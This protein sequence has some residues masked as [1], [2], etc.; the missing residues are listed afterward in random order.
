MIYFDNA[1]TTKIDK[2]AL[3][4]MNEAYEISWA[5]PS[6]LHRL[7]FDSEK[8]IKSARKT[9]ASKLKVSENSIYFSP[10]ATIANN[11]VLKKYDIKGKNI[12]VSVI[13]HSSISNLVVNLE[14]EV[15]FVKV[16]KWGFVNQKDIVD[17]IDENTILV[18]IIHV[19]NEIGSIND[20]NNLAKIVKEKNPKIKFHSDGVQAFKK[21]EVSLDN[22]DYYTISSHKIHGPKGVGALFVRNSN[23]ISPI[24]IGGGQEKGIF[25]G[26]ENIPAIIGF[27]K[28]CELDNNYD[29]VSEINGYLRSEISKID[30]SIILSP[31]ENSSPFILNI[32]IERIG[33]EILLH[34][35]EM[36]DIYIST[37]SACNKKEKSKV[38]EAL[39]LP[40]GF[41][42][43][44][45]RISLSKDNTI[46]EAQIFIEKLHEKIETIRR[47]IGWDGY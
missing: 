43:G 20:I 25:S 4:T 45:I 38:L 14:V 23:E 42:D 13:E 37:G 21:I 24:Y 15:R 39:N 7:G 34:Y 11:T 44:C 28:A 32:C 46:E 41:T 12:I 2:S 26:T 31:V 8:R 6:S 27:E 1:S 35:L 9:I 40:S 17:L 47:I 16:D 19:N 30:G 29:K 10:N 18:S 22:I 5:N 36:E 33:A 3:D